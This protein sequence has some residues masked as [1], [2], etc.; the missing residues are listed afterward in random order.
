M[1]AFERVTERGGR[2][3]KSDQIRRRAIG[4]HCA[5]GSSGLP[6]EM[7]QRQPIPVQ[8]PTCQY[9]LPGC[10]PKFTLS[11]PGRSRSTDHWR[12]TSVAERIF[13]V[14]E[15]EG[16]VREDLSFTPASNASCDKQQSACGTHRGGQIKIKRLAQPPAKANGTMAHILTASQWGSSGDMPYHLELHKS[17]DRGRT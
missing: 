13:R 8:Q 2:C 6:Y 3:I 9:N 16:I 14:I 7:E 17:C 12:N 10:F 5:L 1:H 15:S 11:H 4:L